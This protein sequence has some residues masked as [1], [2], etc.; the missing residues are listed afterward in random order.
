MRKIF[1]RI[2]SLIIIASLI[3]S[4]V[5]FAYGNTT[6]IEGTKNSVFE[7]GELDTLLYWPVPNEYSMSRGFV[8]DG[9]SGIDIN[10]KGIKGS[11]VCAAYDGKVVAYYNYCNHEN[12]GEYHSQTC[13][14]RDH[15][16]FGTGL[17]IE[18]NI[19]GKKCY[20][21]YAHM[22]KDSIPDGIRKGTI[23]EKGQKIGEVGSTGSSTGPHLHFEITMGADAS[24]GYSP[25]LGSI[26]SNPKE[27]RHNKNDQN[28]IDYNYDL[29]HP[30]TPIYPVNIT[31]KTIKNDV[32]MRKDYYEVREIIDRV[33]QKGTK[34][35]FVAKTINGYGNLWYKT[36]DGIWIYSGNLTTLDRYTVTYNANGGKGA[37]NSQAFVEGGS[38]ALSTITPYKQNATFKGWSTSKNGE[39][40]YKPGATYSG[41]S[42]TLYAVWE[43][44]WLTMT[45]SSTK[46][47]LKI[48]KNTSQSITLTL[49]GKYYDVNLTATTSDSSIA[50]ADL[51]KAFA[52][53]HDLTVTAASK[54]G[55]ATVVVY[56]KRNGKTVSSSTIVVNVSKDYIVTYDANN[57]EDAP[58][59][60][61]KTYGQN[62]KIS[63]TVPTR[64]GYNFM[65]W[66]ANS[67]SEIPKYGPNDTF[68][69]N[70]DITLYAV[71]S[72]KVNI[73][74]MYDEATK[75]LT[76][77]G[78]GRMPNY[79]LE[80]PAEWSSYRDS[81]ERIVVKN[82]VQNIG[83]YAFADF[84]N[85]T[86]ISVADSVT[87]IGSGAFYGCTNLVKAT[88]SRFVKNIGEKAFAFCTKLTS[89]NCSAVNTQVVSTMAEE[90]DS[91][92]EFVGAFAFEGCASLTEITLP[93]SVNEIGA[94][95]FSECTSLEEFDIPDNVSVIEDSTF[96]GCS[97]LDMEALPEHITEINDA[98]FS[99]CSSLSVSEI[100]SGIVSLGDQAFSG[101]S[102]IQNITVPSSVTELGA[103]VFSNCTA[104]KKASVPDSL[105]A[106]GDSMFSGCTSLESC[107][108]PSQLKSLGNGTFASCSS[109]DIDGELPET[110]SSIGSSTFYNCTSLSSFA[111]TNSIS[112]IGDYAF[113]GCSSLEFDALPSSLASIGTAAFANCSSVSE[114]VIPAGVTEISSSAFAGCK[115]LSNVEFDN[116]EI[117]INSSAFAN[118]TALSYVEIPE[119]ALYVAPNAFSN[120]S[121]SMSVSCFATSAALESVTSSSVPYEVIYPVSSI[122]IEGSSEVLKKGETVQLTTQ[123]TPMQATNKKVTW[124]SINEDVATVS[125]NGLVTAVSNGTAI[126]RAVTED[127]GY[128]A[129]IEI[130][131]TVPV[132]SVSIDNKT[133]SVYEDSYRFFNYVVTPSNAELTEV[134]FLS[135]DSSVAEISNDGIMK[136]V[137]PGKVTISVLT[138]CGKSDSFELT[139]NEYIPVESIT[140]E[141][142]EVSLNIA[143]KVK[144]N[145]TVSPANASES[146]VYWYSED[147]SIA[148]VDENGMVTAHKAGKVNIFATNADD[149]VS[150]VCNVIVTGSVASIRTP[151]VTTI[152]YGDVIILHTD[153]TGALPAG[154]SIK[155]D[156]SNGNF[157]M[158]VSSDG[159]TC[160]ISPKSSGDTTFT[161]TVVD[162]DKN[163]ISSDEQTMTSKAG[164]FDKIIA[165]FKKL[166]GLTKVI[167]QSLNT[168]Y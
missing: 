22:I 9:H 48:D 37:P 47:N 95:A 143:E 141:K 16:G 73:A 96:F 154:A 163:V 27:D 142:T 104:L 91:G 4:S 100:P 32:P 2:F 157:A 123:L 128:S 150:A 56:A 98:A 112:S 7:K 53:Q 59:A 13:G 152:S 130:E 89:V 72:E 17:I 41:K 5:V 61:T 82:G 23:V 158:D 6:F 144:L 66:S 75:T 138:A 102:S 99:G 40:N 31:L 45:A 106:F 70:R 97:A 84:K 131:C 18:H 1:K 8:S 55:T 115:S 3:I 44:N 25:F 74:C 168:I 39:V 85:V 60:Q 76:I 14:G 116:Q 38:V 30:K 93:N 113:M 125:E 63:S 105:E 109:F 26:N 134:T 10:R 161:A 124:I 69:L 86:S 20:T 80:H 111:F 151:S 87:D 146:D 62:L 19:N 108:I 110:I 51:K 58:A 94:G 34:F 43:P 28:G 148:T 49:Q 159:T 156:A 83:S 57:G 78:K 145:A 114:I 79:S 160:K 29:K 147:D 64:S 164:F 127:G 139:V 88:L 12:G 155:W 167:Q 149:N 133:D 21:H 65:G 71:W 11:D 35:N 137:A 118:C 54:P 81:A 129:E 103:G 77:G 162:A 122:K 132:E 126:I 24:W 68:T 136:A 119:R 90:S 165:F 135:S 117:T 140:I 101:C 153:I 42:I 46:A 15:D 36:A 107:N 52:N 166:F 33:P 50:T 67:A 120:C 92:L 121:S